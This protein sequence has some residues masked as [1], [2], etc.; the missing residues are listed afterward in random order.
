M[1]MI[2]GPQRWPTNIAIRCFGYWPISFV[3]R[4]G[5][6]MDILTFERVRGLGEGRASRRR[7]LE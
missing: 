6:E 7:R 1:G 3:R 5:E 4:V 2:L